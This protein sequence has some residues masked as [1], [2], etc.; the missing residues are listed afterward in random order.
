MA[1]AP[2]LAAL[3]EQSRQLTSNLQSS[4]DIP[5]VELGLD[6]IESAS[7]R[8]GGYGASNAPISSGRL[9]VDATEEGA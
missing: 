9:A 3:L 2:S 1:A 8:L 7:R 4:R 5:H 6:Q